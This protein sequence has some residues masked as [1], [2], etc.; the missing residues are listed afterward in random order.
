MPANLPVES[1]RNVSLVNF[2]AVW[3][4]PCLKELPMLSELAASSR[5][6][7]VKNLHVGDNDEAINGMFSRLSITNLSNA[8]I[9]DFDAVRELGFVGL[10]ATLVTV[11]GAVEFHATG[12]LKTPAGELHQWLQCLGVSA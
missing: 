5:T 2:W 1:D 3:C 10:P 11:N 9:D 4:G 12:Y 7:D 6:F 8:H